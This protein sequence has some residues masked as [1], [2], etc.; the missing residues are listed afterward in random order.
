MTDYKK[1]KKSPLKFVLAEFLM[2]PIMNFAEY[3]PKIQDDLRRDYPIKKEEAVGAIDIQPGSVSIRSDEKQW[4]LLSSNQRNGLL[5]TGN[6]LA[7]FTSEYDRFEGFKSCCSQ[8]LHSLF[9]R[10]NPSLVTRIGFRY[11][12]LIRMGEGDSVSDWVAPDFGLLTPLPSLGKL[13]QKN[14]EIVTQTSEGMLVVRAVLGNHNRVSLPNAQPLP[15]KLDQDSEPS[16]R[17][18]LDLDHSWTPKD[19]TTFDCDDILDKLDSLHKTSRE[20]FWALT[21]DAARGEKWA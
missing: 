20:V 11:G 19:S 4:M 21:T 14:T 6:R 12:N 5:L 9:S 3:I 8:A 13:L 2:S 17:I 7:F 10:S 1:L 15:I 16:T 18:I